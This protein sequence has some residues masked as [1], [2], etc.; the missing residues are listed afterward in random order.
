MLR[1]WLP[2]QLNYRLLPVQAGILVTFALI[3]VWYRFRGLPSFS[4]F[5]SAGFL[6]FWAMVW[7]VGWWVITGL[8]GLRAVLKSRLG[9]LW[10]VLLIILAGWSWLSWLWSY[11]RLTNPTVTISSAIPLTLVILFAIAASCA[12]PHNRYIAIVVVVSLLWNS[13]VAGLQVA[14]QNEIGLQALGE[15]KAD[16]SQSGTVIVQAGDMRWLRPYGLLPH[17]N[18]LAGFLAVVLLGALGWTVAGSGKRWLVGTSIAL[19]G[20]WNLLLTFSRAAWLGFGAGAGL[21][22]LYLVCIQKPHPPAPSPLAERGSQTPL[23]EFMERFSLWRARQDR[24]MLVRLLTT[25]GLMIMAVG[26]FAILYQPFLAARAGVGDESIELRSVSDR[27]VYNQIAFEVIGQSPVLGIGL[28][29][30]PWYA[31]SYLAKT[32]FDLKGQPVHN[33]FLSAWTELGLVGLTLTLA[34]T[35]LGG[36]IAAKEIRQ[37]QDSEA[38]MRTALLAGVI[39]LMVIG[40]F[41]HYPWTLPQFQVA[42]WGLLAVAGRVKSES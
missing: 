40:L 11:T 1:S 9:L 26:V 20:L 37:A 38:V 34:A 13:V 41:D 16:P 24:S 28:G 7:T 39:T 33:I 19:L 5:Y 27:A 6:I 17:P 2:Q 3:P 22:F 30:F 10:V 18:M 21:L 14:S 15:F 23:Q 42:W 4:T 8:P 25:G 31:A 32:D 35:L 29:N 36:W 12:A